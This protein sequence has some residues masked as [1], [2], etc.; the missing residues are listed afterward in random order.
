[1]NKSRFRGVK[2][3]GT[4]D[5]VEFVCGGCG[6]VHTEPRELVLRTFMSRLNAFRRQHEWICRPAAELAD[7]RA[8]LR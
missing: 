5:G 1:M 8:A 4:A 6:K 2:V 7:S 3:R